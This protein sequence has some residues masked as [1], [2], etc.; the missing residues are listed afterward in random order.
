MTSQNS[1][2]YK[3]TK[4]CD[5]GWI[6]TDR[7]SYK[8]CICVDLKFIKKCWENYGVKPEA[9]KTLK[10]YVSYN[11][12]CDAAK[13]KAFNYITCFTEIKERENNWFG[14]FG[15]SG[16]GKSHIVIALGSELLNRKD[17][18]VRAV[19]MPYIEVMRELKANVLHDEYYI[20]LLNRYQRAEVLIIDDLFKDKV[21]KNK[22][23]YELS[24]ADIKHIY[25]IINYRYFNKLPTVISSECT[26]NML[27][28]LDEALGGRILERC[29]ENITVF[30]GQENNYRLKKFEKN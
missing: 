2:I 24:E 11:K 27:I 7:N 25:P 9:V 18:P 10:D 22:L 21:K 19:Y 8:K 13:Q 6:E 16:S 14:V 4:C 3:C 5:T 28:D 26:P 15:Q 23:A 1:V 20:K 17:K 30:M 12:I 29:N